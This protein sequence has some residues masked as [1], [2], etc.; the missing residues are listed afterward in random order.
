MIGSSYSAQ[1]LTLQLI[2]FGATKVIM[3]HHRMTSG[4][5]VPNGAEERPTVQSF[6]ESA[7]YFKD[8]TK[9]EIDVNI[10]CT[11]YRLH[12]PFLPENLRIKPEMSF[13][14]DNLYKG[15]V[16]M[17]DGN[18]KF[19]YLGVLSMSFLNLIDVQALW[20]CQYIMN[21]EQLP[22]EEMLVDI[23]KY[24][25]GKDGIVEKG[26]LKEILRFTSG[27]L[28]NLVEATGY[29]LDVGKLESVVLEHVINMYADYSTYRDKQ[30]RSVQT[31][32][33]SAAPKIPWMKDFRDIKEIIEADFEGR[34]NAA[35]GH[36]NV[37]K[38]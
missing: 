8:A 35:E 6:D 27:Y 7:A 32:Q 30:F 16:W 37:I 12:H 18:F 20:V 22:R 1:D 24:V 29:Q 28:E 31:G 23:Q 13:Y 5:K 3:S 17:K 38:N 36:I 10:F 34:Y 21:H 19:M 4:I 33:M 25:T 26:D 2:K 15:I 14:P 9:E 11:G